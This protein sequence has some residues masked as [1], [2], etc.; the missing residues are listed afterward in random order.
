MKLWVAFLL[1]A[2]AGA[3][4]AIS[5]DQAKDI[6]SRADAA[7]AK[8]AERGHPGCAVGAYQDG[9]TLYEGAFGLANLEHSVPI[10]PKR[11]VFDIASVSKQFTAASILLLVQDGKLKLDDDIRKYLPEMPDYGHVITIDHLLHHT[12]G[13]RDYITL[14]LM[15]GKGWWGDSTEQDGLDLIARQKGLNFNPGAKHIYSNTGYFLASVIVRRVSGKT[16]ASF[17]Q[18]RIFKPL[19][20]TNTYFEDRLGRVTPHYASGYTPQDEGTFEVR[21]TRWA[22]YGDGGLRT[23]I[24]DIAKWQRN[25]DGPK[26]GG[27]WLIEQLEQKGVLNDGRK[28]QYAR[29]LE[30][31]DQEGEGY[32]GL[33]TVEH[34][35]AEWTGYRSNVMRITRDKLSIAALCNSGEANPVQ[36]TK[37]I[38]DVFMEG[39]LPPQQVATDQD[40]EPK[41][42]APLSVSDLPP[43]LLGVYW[44]R[45][46][47]KV[48]RIELSD[49]KLWYVRSSQSRSELVPI[50]NGQFRMIG[51]P[52]KS[53]VEMLPSKTGPQII[54]IVSRTPATLEKVEPF[55]PAA[56]PDYVGTYTS[57]ELDNASM[58]FE[59]DDGKLTGFDGLTPAF[60][61]AFLASGNE[62]LLRFQRNASGRVTSLLV[63]LPSV[64]N[65]AYT[66]ETATRGK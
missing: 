22:E 63:D 44:N 28:I 23:T 45:E 52:A 48:R 1:S 15:S 5:A 36:L 51:V 54:R 8:Y 34:S 10:D 9:K 26:V 40:P 25:F 4:A 24:P 53:I 27:T 50:G 3:A 47:V 66:R 62:M 64:R 12:S 19:G 65:M 35:G 30:V 6:K 56:L 13:L 18:E 41:P 39:K 57:G 33:R 46:D 11:T 49:G 55:S 31:F 38:A 58:T 29:G 60:K 59:I 7:M 61:D 43:T 2:I 37:E 21:S 32:H 42:G 20:M 17:A 16:L 14:R